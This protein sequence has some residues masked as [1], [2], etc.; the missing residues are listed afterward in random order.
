VTHAEGAVLSAHLEH[1]DA[2]PRQR[3]FP[4]Q[5]WVTSRE[6]LRAVFVEGSSP[7]ALELRYRPDVTKALPDAPYSSGFFGVARREHLAD[8]AV[9]VR[10]VFESGAQ[11]HWFQL[12]PEGEALLFARARRLER[13]YPT[14]RCIR[15]LNGFPESGYAAGATRIECRECGATYDCSQGL[16]DLLAD[17]ARAPLALGSDGNI[18]QNVY[19]ATAET[20]I[21]EDPGAL[22]LDCGAGLR[23]LEYPNVVNLEVVPYRTTDV[24]G[25]NERLPFKDAS[26]DGA[27]SLAVL[28]HV[29]NPIASAKEICRVLKPGG[30]LLAVVPLIA[31]VHAYPHHYFNMTAE[32][33]ASLFDAEIDIED[34]RVPDSGLPVWALVWMLR[35]WAEGLPPKARAS[36]T[37]M[38]VGDLLGEAPEYLERDFVTELPRE[39]N[40]EL[41]G[42]TQIFG[43]KRR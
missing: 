15:C 11:V 1:P 32:G 10:F 42:T 36:F 7:A 6:P 28:E 18:S 29:R 9:A 40:F 17:D 35:S 23:Q 21:H 14:L 12:E 8:G 22:I 19:D 26:F 24:L 31:P 2:L 25:D 13:I 3:E 34:R 30:K 33:L 16:F 39:K 37:S 4:V 27:L 20:F 41:A 5:G 38:R 43:R